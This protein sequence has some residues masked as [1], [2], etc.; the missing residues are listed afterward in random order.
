MTV[1]TKIVDKA[2]RET[3]LER[4]RRMRVFSSLSRAFENAL[5]F[6]LL[7][8]VWELVVQSDVFPRV[9]MPSLGTVAETFWRMLLDGSL[10]RDVSSSLVR[11]FIG[12]FVAAVVGIALGLLMGRYRWVERFFLP[13]LSALMPIPALAWIPL[14][15]LWF[16]LG[17]VAIFAVV[18]FGTVLPICFNTWTGM[19]SVNPVWL[20]AAESMKCRGP[21]LFWRV[22][23]P[24]S[25]GM[26]MA[27]LRIG[28]AQAW[29]ALVAGEM[30]AGSNWGLGWA[31]FNAREFLATDVMLVMIGCIGFFGF[32]IVF[33]LFEKVEERTV[34][35]WGM[36][37]SAAG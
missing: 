12:F 36:L 28:L 31:I 23:F 3:I 13:L 2:D 8:I 19:K 34:V 30:L 33:L 15:I 17:D 37:S 16:G 7:A 5:P 35:R 9:L 21:R 27:G 11:L 20:R 4:H 24:G 26:I 1:E 25:L 14:F 18:F 29:R 10:L 22:I 32:I 6:I